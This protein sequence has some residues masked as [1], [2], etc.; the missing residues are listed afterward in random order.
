M[1]DLRTLLDSTEALLG[2][3]AALA[4]RLEKR[5][6]WLL[7]DTRTAELPAVTVHVRP[8]LRDP[9]CPA[10]FR[11]E[12]HERPYSRMALRSGYGLI[13]LTGSRGAM[14]E[15]GYQALQDALDDEVPHVLVCDGESGLSFHDGGGRWSRVPHPRPVAQRELRLEIHGSGSMKVDRVLPCR[16][17]VESPAARDSFRI[18][19]EE[20]RGFRETEIPFH[21]Q[22][23]GD[24]P[25]GEGWLCLDFVPG[26]EVD[27]LVVRPEGFSPTVAIERM[28]GRRPVRQRSPARLH[29]LFDR[30]TLD[31]ESWPRAFESATLGMD[32]RDAARVGD[33]PRSEWNLGL[34]RALAQALTDQLHHPKGPARIELW[35]FADTPQPGIDRLEGLPVAPARWG[36]A[37]ACAPL[38]LPG[39]L[40][41]SVFGYASG[42]DLFDAV[43][44][45]IVQV[46]E[47]TKESPQEQHAVLVVGDSPPPPAD[48]QDPVWLG[49]VDRPLRTNAR[50][51]PLFR[52]ALA[53]L[54]E[55]QIPVGWLF[56][57]H[58]AD[59]PANPHFVPH[60]ALYQTL[61]ESTLAALRRYGPAL[62]LESADGPEDLAR[63]LGEILRQMAGR[64]ELPSRLVPGEWS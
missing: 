26:E 22:T 8:W 33:D 62:I 4:G 7:V 19:L 14:D 25:L 30:T 2:L 13:F 59:P 11:I 61:R 38:H 49:L 36:R 12:E 54:G 15:A 57:R 20:R 50:R 5:Q 58:S 18:R 16:V 56:L 48:E 32:E 1:S 39:R 21:L 41:G 10:T 17:R 9:G 42:L 29:L 3:D 45:L 51:S 34:R 37:G 64:R 44:E 55:L 23:S 53:E 40:T 27:R 28:N 6:G 63:A 24:V 47:A 43:D 60:Y 52:R 31:L 35:W 46:A